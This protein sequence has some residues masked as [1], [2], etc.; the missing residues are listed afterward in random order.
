[1]KEYNKEQC[2]S[3]MEKHQDKYLKWEHRL[4]ECKEELFTGWMK[5]VLPS[6]KLWRGYY[7][8][9]VLQ[10]GIDCDGLWMIPEEGFKV[11]FSEVIA[12]DQEVQEALEKEAIK[13]GF[14]E[15]VKIK[16]DFKE[17][18]ECTYETIIRT[19]TTDISIT[20]NHGTFF[21]Y[22]DTHIFCNGVW[23]EII[24]EPVHE[25]QWLLLAHGVA[26][27]TKGFYIESKDICLVDE[28]K[29]LHRIGETKRLRK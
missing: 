7:E 16:R 28:I 21:N 23:A 26:E 10:Y 19:T 2:K 17:F 29:V 14:K 1:M 9:G 3:K 18:G 11:E 5:D 6:S 27:T 22:G 12:T 8:N 13:R 25:Y 20:I 15:G 4:K 24:T